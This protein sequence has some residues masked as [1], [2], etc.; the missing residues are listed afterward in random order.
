ME[1]WASDAENRDVNEQAGA[2]AKA[3]VVDVLAEKRPDGKRTRKNLR[4]V[5]TNGKA[6]I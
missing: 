6:D 5:E 4:P 2:A 1:Q 3:A